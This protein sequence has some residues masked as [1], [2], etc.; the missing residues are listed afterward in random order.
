LFIIQEITRYDI[1]NE[2]HSV[3]ADG[4]LLDAWFAS[5]IEEKKFDVSDRLAAIWDIEASEIYTNTACEN[6]NE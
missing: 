3:L 5:K 1:R 6:E 2:Q 4:F